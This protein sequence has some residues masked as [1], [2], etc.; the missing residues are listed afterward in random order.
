MSLQ[1]LLAEM[2]IGVVFLELLRLCAYRIIKCGCKLLCCTYKNVSSLD[3]A[4]AAEHKARMVTSYIVD[5]ISFFFFKCIMLKLSPDFTEC[6]FTEI[7]KV[8]EPLS[9]MSALNMWQMAFGR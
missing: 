5:R 9:E 6:T 8:H 1:E 2:R 4:L 7:H 3:T